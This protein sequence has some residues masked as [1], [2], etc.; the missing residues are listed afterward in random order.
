MNVSMPRP[1]VR[2]ES[3]S[4][5]EYRI[6]IVNRAG[7]SD[8]DLSDFLLTVYRKVNPAVPLETA[9]PN[10]KASRV[11]GDLY[12][13]GPVLF[14]VATVDPQTGAP[15]EKVGGLKVSSKRLPAT[16]DELRSL[17]FSVLE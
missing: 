4:P 15:S 13:E 7:M 9:P 12:R 3:V 1:E 10:V 17:G 2:V 6:R 11:F 16:L 14:N 5:D 8:N